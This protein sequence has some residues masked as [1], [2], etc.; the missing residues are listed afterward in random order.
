MT[1]VAK[2]F[3]ANSTDLSQEINQMLG[4]E[5]ELSKVRSYRMTLNGRYS[6]VNIF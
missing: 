2:I 4:F 5:T 3:K 6:L 1:G